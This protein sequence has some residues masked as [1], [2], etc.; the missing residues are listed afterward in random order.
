MCCLKVLALSVWSLSSGFIADLF[1]QSMIG[2]EVRFEIVKRFR[3][4]GVDLPYQQHDAMHSIFADDP[5]IGAATAV[6][7]PDIVEAPVIIRKPA[8]G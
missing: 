6:L 2:T 8:K 4:D 5:D 3:Q 7:E 1:E